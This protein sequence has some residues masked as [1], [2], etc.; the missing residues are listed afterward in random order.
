MKIIRQNGDVT[1]IRDTDGSATFIRKDVCGGVHI[2][3]YERNKKTPV[4]GLSEKSWRG[5]K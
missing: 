5:N 3:T 4:S 2:Q 1:E